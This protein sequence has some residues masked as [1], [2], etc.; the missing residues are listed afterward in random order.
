MSVV[1]F[2]A[3]GDIVPPRT[4]V[5]RFIALSVLGLT[6]MVAAALAVGVSTISVTCAAAALAAA[7]VLSAVMLRLHHPH[8]RLGG[9]NV[10]TLLRLS[11]TGLLLSIL[12]SGGGERA[13]VLAVSIVAVCLDGVDGCIA[14]H[15]GLESRFG[16]AF[17]V[18]VDS[19]FALV[20]SLLA[21]LGPAGPLALLLG[22]PRYLFG[23]AGLAF[24]W[25]N[26]PLVPRFSRKVVCVV[27]LG[28]LIAL[29]LPL[30]PVWIALTLV[31]AT[32]AL[33][34]WSFGRD[35]VDLARSRPRGTG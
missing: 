8:P 11:M 3:A 23:A 34:A 29:Q 7:L 17:D 19:V 10:I 33:L 28:V 14:R 20:L 12:L 13:V 18:E 2:N 21:A 30:L 6:V 25:L 16:A 9:A 31:M 27:Q 24:P 4:M 22:L 1:R 26:A 32:A 5:W 35:V 15:Q